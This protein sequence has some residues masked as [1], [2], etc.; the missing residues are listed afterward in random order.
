MKRKTADEIFFG[1]IVKEW[2]DQKAEEKSGRKWR[3]SGILVEICR[4][5]V[6]MYGKN[7]QRVLKTNSPLRAHEAVHFQKGSK[8]NFSVC[9]QHAF[10]KVKNPW[11]NWPVIACDLHSI[12]LWRLSNV[13]VFATALAFLWLCA[14]F[15]MENRFTAEW[16]GFSKD[17]LLF[18]IFYLVSFLPFPTKNN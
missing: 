5:P 14:I 17:S 16:T 13:N 10:V 6:D 3:F 15:K 18:L 4:F 12:T 7:G 9:H 11:S 2:F 1:Y 8:C